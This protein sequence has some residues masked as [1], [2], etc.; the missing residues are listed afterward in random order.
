MKMIVKTKAMSSANDETRQI[1]NPRVIRD[2]S[3]D[4]FHALRNDI[5]CHYGKFDAR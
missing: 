2:G 4:R 5:H 1:L 3:I